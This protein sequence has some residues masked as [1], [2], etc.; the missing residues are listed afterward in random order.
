MF[1]FEEKNT[2]KCKLRYSQK[3]LMLSKQ[4]SRFESVWRMS[5]FF[6]TFQNS[7]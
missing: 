4:A 2:S 1:H 6:I 3:Q 7:E 5:D